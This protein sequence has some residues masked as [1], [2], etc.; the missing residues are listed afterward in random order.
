VLVPRDPAPCSEELGIDL[1]KRAFHG[2][3][4]GFSDVGFFVTAASSVSGVCCS[5]GSP[6]LYEVAVVWCWPLGLSGLDRV[7]RARLCW[8]LRFFL[9]QRVVGSGRTVDFSTHVLHLT[10]KGALLCVRLVSSSLV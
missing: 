2:V 8:L 7:G 6:S 5:T 3:G 4:G 1:G 10:F 9:A